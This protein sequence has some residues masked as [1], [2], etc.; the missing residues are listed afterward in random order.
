MSVRLFIVFFLCAA[1]VS[2]GQRLKVTGETN[3]TGKIGEDVTAP[4]VITNTSD[5]PVTLAIKRTET[6][7]ASTQQTWFCWDADCFDKEV[8]IFPYEKII[9]PGESV[10]AFTST[11]RS[12]LVEGNSLVKYII[13]DKYAPEEQVEVEINYMI[14]EFLHQAA[15][16]HS[17]DV[18]I[19]DVYPNPVSEHAIIDYKITNP[20]VKVKVVL[21]SVLGS[22]MG[23]FVLEPLETI[24]KINAET[25]NPGV[26]FY[27]LYINNDGM[28]T[29][30]LIVKK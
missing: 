23:E 13:Y 1:A 29:R 25:F 17:K 11:L 18:V 9:N 26:Y 10:K 3:V 6:S 27:T 30:K 21:H 14:K 5:R 4:I 28:M 8:E 16:F 15:L 2:Y 7:I 24:F 22:V 20:D 12:G 19:N